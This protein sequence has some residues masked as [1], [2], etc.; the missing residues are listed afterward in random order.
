MRKGRARVWRSFGLVAVQLA[1][2]GIILL[3]GP[4]IPHGAA[5]FL[6]LTVGSVLGVWAVA[7]M[8]PGRFNVTPDVRPGAR[9]VIR[10]P[11]RVIRHPMYASL[12]LMTLALVFNR[13][14]II[15]WGM[16]AILFIDMLVKLRY[17]ESLL[18]EQFPDYGVYR[19]KTWRLV[20]F[21]Y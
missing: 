14:T 17:E 13:M 15:R 1:A 4:W 9:M 6:L 10:G 21:V 12:L 20:P 7:I 19:E 16:W 18:A 11:Y 8:A 3:T 2:L 5:D